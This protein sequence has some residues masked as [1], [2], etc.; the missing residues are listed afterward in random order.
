M[1]RFEKKKAFLIVPTVEFI[2]LEVGQV[3]H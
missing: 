1:I 3:T 2:G